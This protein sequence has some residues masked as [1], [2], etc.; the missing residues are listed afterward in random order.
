[1]RIRTLYWLLLY[2]FVI[3]TIAASFSTAQTIT[4]AFQ[5][6]VTDSSGAVLPGAQ[7]TASNVETGLKRT[8]TTGDEGRFLLSELPPGSYEITVTL[9]GFETLVRKGLTLTVGQ[10]ASLALAMKVGAVGEQLVVTGDA[11][12]VETTQ[13]SV[14]GVVEERRITELPLNGR[15]FTQLALV[16]PAVVSLRN[17]G[18]GEVGRGFGVRMSVAGSRPD[19]TSWLLDG[20]NIKGS[21]QFGTP[22]SAGGGLLGVDGVREFQVLTTNY[23]SEFGG[24]SG[25]VVNMVTKS[26]TNQFHGTVY[27]FLRNSAL[28]AAAWEDNAFG[29]GK[30]PFKRNQF[31]FSLG[32]PIRKDRT[33]FFFNYE[34]LRQPKGFTKVGVVPDENAHKGLVPALNGSGLQQV[35]IADSIA[36]LLKLW[37]TPNVPGSSA[38][39][40]GFLGSS[41]TQR[42]SENYYMMRLDHSLSES[43]SLFGRF[44]FDQASQDNP[45]LIPVDNFKLETKPRYAT[46]QL[47]SIWTPKL[48]STT[49]VGVNRNN[50]GLN[51][52]MNVKY[53]RNVFFLNQ[54]FPPEIQIPG[55]GLSNYGPDASNVQTTIQQLYQ[56]QE[57][58]AYTT[59]NHSLKFGF[60]FDKMDPN[61]NGGP[62]NNGMFR[63][64]SI[65]D[66][67]QDNPLQ[68]LSTSL[69]GNQ[70]YR[71]FRQNLFGFYFNDD[72]KMNS[73]L[74]WNLGLRYEPYTA[75][76]EKWGRVSVVKDWLTATHY[77]TGG[78]MFQSP[79]NKY[80]AP[81]VGFAFDPQGNGKTAIRGG[82]GVFYVPLTTYVYSRAATRNA[83]FSGS[84]QQTPRDAQGR[85]ANFAS[86]LA[87]VNSIAPGFLTPQFG[88]TTSPIM[89]QYRPDASYEM[90]VNLTVE[91]QIGQDFSVSVGYVG[92]RGFHLTRT[93]DVNVRYP[94]IVNGRTF[95]DGRNP[96]PNPALFQ[97]QL[98][99]TDSQSFY[100]A[101]RT[102]LKK[103]FSRSYQFQVSYTWSKSIDDA[104][105][106][107]SNTAYPTE[108]T[109]SQLWRTKADRGLSALNQTHN[110]VVN[111]IWNLP[112]PS[113]PRVVSSLLGGWEV[114]GIFTAVSGTPFTPTI[115]GSNVNDNGKPGGGSRLRMPDWVGGRSFSSITSGTT[116]GCTFLGGIP[117]PYIAG[118]PNSVAPGRKLGTPV[119]WFDPCAFAVPPA[120]FYGNLGRGTLIGPGTVN[121]DT[122][123]G[124]NIALREGTRLEFRSEFFNIFNRPNFADPANQVLN[125]NNNTPI[126]TAGQ[127]TSTVTSSRQ[128]QFS[129][130][131]V[132]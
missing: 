65:A 59:G 23:S 44:S 47:V 124:K 85:V 74:T 83:P 90:K 51:I 91:R 77:D 102:Q 110:L 54:D 1:M 105:A 8:T 33:F 88:P 99:V 63:W 2:S 19:Q 93:T 49:R 29:N 32:G 111:G 78:Q 96:V 101:L 28:D 46:I 38:G 127:I 108:G 61:L 98:V 21:T 72:W 121:F 81:R 103:R 114:T 40:V 17:T 118:R 69:P 11:P 87:Y 16:E 106:G 92:G 94:T 12:I 20:M 52:A 36:D 86:A 70:P 67:L 31:G 62:N 126:S 76:S 34:G 56:V 22:G 45:D 26:G 79:G 73:K 3:L 122:S 115:S 27:E 120:G 4:A 119:L 39:G 35:K 10:Q 131:L 107:S 50:I 104:T 129:L 5:G 130:K 132:F 57:S 53:P 6:T 48:L 24:T 125:A 123:L 66:F 7:V 116:A 97:G 9:A 42:T 128:L 109:S 75:P 60:D 13:S 82:F 84:I 30:P 18:S 41:V 100:N 68:Q 80:F 113:G 71:T 55:A 14:A 64:A 58:I 112:S 43:Q 95:V 25:G 117:G 15:D 89:V 37:P